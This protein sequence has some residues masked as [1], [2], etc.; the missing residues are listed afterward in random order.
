MKRFIIRGGRP[1]RGEVKIS[2]AKNA[3]LPLLFATLI[4]PGTSRLHGVPDI[5]DVRVALSILSAYGARIERQGDSLTV[6]TDA[7][8]DTVP[9]VEAVTAIRA[10]T[11]LLGAALARFGHAWLQPFG[12]C[13]FADRPIDL[14][15]AAAAAFGARR[16]GDE[17]RCT[18]LC[19]VR[20]T[21]PT[22]SVGATVN[23][24]LLAATAE[25][26]SL[27]TGAAEEPHVAALIAF[28]CSGGADIRQV[29]RGAYRVV[30]RPLHGGEATVIPDMIEAVTYLLAAPMTGGDITVTGVDPTQLAA[31][32]SLLERSGVQ[33]AYAP[34]SLRACG[35]ATRPITLYTY[36]YP[37]FPTDLHPPFAA[38]LSLCGGT[39]C[40]QVFPER[41]GYLE[42]LSAFGLRYTRAGQVATLSPSVLHAARAM[43][44]D[45]R[46]GA[47]LLLA[48]L[49][50]RGESEIEGADTVLRGYAALPDKLT[51]LG[52]DILLTDLP[53]A[54]AGQG[55]ERNHK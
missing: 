38:L 10:S 51:R 21:F 24:L 47:A 28:L 9:P 43:A 53:S 42:G 35:R 45:L 11:Y 49:H 50:A 33:V 7:V 15:L 3:A 29:G 25:G 32:L 16:E 41:F 8:Q 13:R 19:G 5:G 46:G 23:A 2:G 34:T 48:A 31:P 26:E 37:G 55:S 30:G 12:G 44:T 17:L 54:G 20:H 18:R 4:L 27:I 36:P 39:V 1:L 14:H 22:V 6:C 52:A 40:E